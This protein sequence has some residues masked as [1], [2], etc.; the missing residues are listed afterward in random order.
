VRLTNNPQIGQ[1]FEKVIDDKGRLFIKFFGINSALNVKNWRVTPS[2][3]RRN[4]YSFLGK[5]YIIYPDDRPVGRDFH[6][7]AP[8]G[9]S[10]ED[11]VRAGKEYAAGYIIDISDTSNNFAVKTGSATPSVE[12]DYFFT[13]EI[14]DPQVKSAFLKNE[15][16]IPPFVSPAI[17][18]NPSD[19]DDQIEDW[20]G[21]HLAAVPL[22]AYGMKATAIAHCSGSDKECIPALKTASA[23]GEEVEEYAK[24]KKQHCMIDSLTSLLQNQN[25]F[26]PSIKMAYSPQTNTEEPSG[27]APAPN[28]VSREIPRLKTLERDREREQKGA[29]KT[30]TTVT[31]KEEQIQEDQQNQR[32]NPVDS[33]VLEEVRRL[34]QEREEE[35]KRREEKEAK[36]ERRKALEKLIPK[37]LFW[38]YRHQRFEDKAYEEEFERRLND[39]SSLDVLKELY[40]EKL[41][42]LQLIP[43]LKTAGLP[44]ESF[45]GV[46]ETKTASATIDNTARAKALAALELAPFHTVEVL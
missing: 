18:H 22:G 8:K 25:N 6:K 21:V 28:N 13:V 29:I 24:H 42:T 20:L 41:Q 38:N 9:S 19:K 11:H 23:L 31:K 3:I 40:E 37:G 12:D 34:R 35:N 45:S 32:P 39:N 17:A 36:D 44:E 15:K 14:T 2:S 5:P 26:I 10:Y 27:Q 30:N 33:E 1:A 46:P 4:I 43:T 16:A 7:L